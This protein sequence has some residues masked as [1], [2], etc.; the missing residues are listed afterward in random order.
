MATIGSFEEIEAWMK[1]RKL[2]VELV[3]IFLR[4]GARHDFALKDQVNRSIGSVMDNI[5][6]GFERGGNKE[7]IQF[8]FIA[9]GSAGETRSQLCRMFDRKYISK[10]EFD[11]LSF[12]LESTSKLLMNFISYLKNSEM[13]GTK[14]HDPASTYGTE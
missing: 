8:L 12:E 7:F 5:A 13:K 11:R 14:F 10:E 2:S 4:D 3:N 1:A 6:E 9:K